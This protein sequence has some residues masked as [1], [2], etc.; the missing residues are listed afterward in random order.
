[1]SWERTAGSFETLISIC[2]SHGG[3]SQKILVSITHLVI[4]IYQLCTVPCLV[5]VYFRIDQNR[6]NTFRVCFEHYVRP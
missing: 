4:S 2:H 6:E 3:I 5:L 1:M